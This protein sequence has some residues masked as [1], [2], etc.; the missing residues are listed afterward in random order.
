MKNIKNLLA[1]HIIL[2]VIELPLACSFWTCMSYV[3][4]CSVSETFDDL[5]AKIE[6]VEKSILILIGQLQMQC[7]RTVFPKIITKNMKS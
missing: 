3:Y 7:V 1:F 2:L 6:Q 4:R 5:G